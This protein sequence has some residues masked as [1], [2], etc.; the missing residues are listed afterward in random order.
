MNIGE[1]RQEKKDRAVVSNYLNQIRTSSAISPENKKMLLEYHDMR[2][3][4]GHKIGSDVYTLRILLTLSE[5]IKKPYKKITQQELASFFNS[6]LM[7]YYSTKK[8][9]AAYSPKTLWNYKASI[10]TFFRWVYGTEEDEPAPQVVK[11]IKRKTISKDL[12]R[13][14]PK[15]ILTKEEIDKLIQTAK[16][17]RD[18]AII[19]VLFESGMRAGELLG[20]NEKDITFYSNYAEWEI[21][22]KTGKR[23]VWIVEAM[24]YLRN[25]LTWLKEHP[26]A[27]GNTD[28]IWVSVYQDENKEGRPLATYSLDCL[29]K[30]LA[31]KA[32]IN[33]RIWTHL[34]RHSSATY[35]ATVIGLSEQELR[36]KYGWT[37]RSDMPSIYVNTNYENI[38]NKHLE[39]IGV[40]ETKQKQTELQFRECPHCHAKNPKELKVC[41]HCREAMTKEGIKESAEQMKASFMLQIAKEM[42]KFSPEQFKGLIEVLNTLEKSQAEKGADLLKNKQEKERDKT[43]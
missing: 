21:N 31:K 8:G 18:K 7:R 42:N 34:V 26:T 36:T 39:R 23:K 27:K 28:N 25:W 29:I 6:N 43:T 1:N 12:K 15:E 14:L 33:R 40:K 19:S 30:R 10:K 3:G 35:F 22:G 37:P 24:P 17:P 2:Q 20:M 32:K 5:N 13:T 16:H 11:W 4:N 41:Y 38:K 9:K